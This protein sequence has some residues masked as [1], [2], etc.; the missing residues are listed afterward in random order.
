MAK[1]TDKLSKQIQRDLGEIIDAAAAQLLEGVMVTIMEVRVT[2][3]LGLAKVYVSIFNTD[4]KE[5]ELEILKSN[6]PQIRHYL[7]GKLRG[8]VRKIPEI[9]IELDERIDRAQHIEELLN[10]IKKPDQNS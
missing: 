9:A 6:L 8:Q 5:R 2:P 3:D 7:A 4:D 1:R 10:K